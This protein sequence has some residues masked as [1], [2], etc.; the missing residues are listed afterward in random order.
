V[1]EGS[2]SIGEPAGITELIGG[3]V[4]QNLSRDPTRRLRDR[5]VVTIEAVDAGVAV[6]LRSAEG[7]I[8]VTDGRDPGARVVVSASSTK[9]LELAGAPLRF[10]LPDALSHDGRV[11]IGDLLTR[12]IRVQGLIRHLG[13]VRRLTMLL[14][15]R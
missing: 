11:L 9:L 15:A 6:S 8:L 14:S 13:T 1:S 7:T 5:D 3:L 2:A 10:G 4:R 12:R